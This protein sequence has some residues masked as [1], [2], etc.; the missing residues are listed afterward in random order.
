MFALHC[1]V[2]A[3]EALG[4]DT[5]QLAHAAGEI[6][7]RGFIQQMHMV[8]HQAVG[9]TAP[10]EAAPHPGQG[11]KKRLAVRIVA[12]DSLACVAA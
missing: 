8:V 6:G 12:K 1:Y 5:V 10:P 3:V 11:G 7:L 2:A 4:I 9:V